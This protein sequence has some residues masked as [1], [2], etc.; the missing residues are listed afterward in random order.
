MSFVRNICVSAAALAAALL[1][2][3]GPVAAAPVATVAP[4]DDAYLAAAHQANLAEITISNLAATHQGASPVV[5][6]LGAQFKDD[7]QKL[8]DA[9]MSVAQQQGVALPATPDT[10][11]QALIQQMQ[12]LTRAEFD[13]AFVPTQ[14]QAHEAAMAATQA[15]IA[16]GQDP[17]VVQLAKDALPVITEHHEEL[18]AA[19]KQL[20][21]QLPPAKPA[22]TAPR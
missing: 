18:L 20:N 13:Q 3:A 10:E 2:A 9:L 19:V 6:R 4:P 1:T 5:V 21:I 8:D 16:K 17:A 15:E 7:H 14:L 22:G 12:H 11:Q